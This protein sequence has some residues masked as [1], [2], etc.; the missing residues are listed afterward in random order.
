MFRKTVFLTLVFSAFL[1]FNIFAMPKNRNA[2]EPVRPT[3]MTDDGY[4]YGDRWTWLND[5][6]CVQFRTGGPVT[7]STTRENLQERFD[8]GM[9]IPW[10]E[11]GEVKK[12]DTYEG[13]WSQDKDGVWSFIFDDGT[14]PID[15]MNIDGVL[16]AFNGYGELR[17][18][19]IYYGKPKTP[20]DSEGCL[21]TGP[22]GLVT[23]DSADFQAWL[24]TQYVPECTSHE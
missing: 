19:V 14:I 21:K 17:E 4:E 12:R 2:N 18:G 8:Y 7:S 13:R 11:N 3:P 16:Y 1:S 5:S 9:L 20:Y 22:D 6:T 15:I 23:A 10:S 24:A